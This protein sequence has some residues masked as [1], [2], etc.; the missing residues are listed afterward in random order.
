MLTVWPQ[1]PSKKLNLKCPRPPP[2][3]MKTL[4]HVIRSVSPVRGDELTSV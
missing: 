1:P 2:E 3:A 4:L